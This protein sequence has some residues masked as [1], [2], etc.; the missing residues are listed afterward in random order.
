MKTR[1]VILSGLLATSLAA[2]ADDAADQKEY[3][4]GQAIYEKACKTCH[5]PETAPAMKAPPVHDQD[6]WKPRL[7]DAETQVKANPTLYK[8]VYDYLV[9]VVRKGKNNMVPGGMCVDDTTPDKKCKDEDYIAAIK[10]MSGPE[11]K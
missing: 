9:S 7:A 10:F 2:H 4:Q 11:K 3:A 1:I 6:A 5:A 8:T